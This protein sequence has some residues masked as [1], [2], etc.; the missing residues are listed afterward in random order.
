MEEREMLTAE[1][2]QQQSVP[3]ETPAVAATEEIAA[4]NEEITQAPDRT[5]TVPSVSSLEEEVTEAAAEEPAGEPKAPKSKKKLLIVVGAAAAVALAAFLAV[6][7]LVLKPNGTYADAEAALLAGNF[8]ECERLLDQI[9]NHEKTPGLRSRMEKTI[10]DNTYA[11]A[12]KALQAGNFQ[13]C[14]RL[15][16][17]IPDHEKVPALRTRLDIAIAEDYIASGKLTMAEGVLAKITGNDRAKE[18]KADIQ[19]L[20]AA[21]LVEKGDVDEAK[22]LLDKIPEHEDPRQLH[23]KI[24]YQQALAALELG[25]YETAYAAFSE[26]GDYEDSAKQKDTVYYEALAFKSLFNVQQT[27]KNP[28][29]LRVTKVSFYDSG[30]ENGELDAV[31]EI[32]ATNSY[33][34]SLGAYAYDFRLYDGTDDSGMISHSAYADPDDY[35]ELLQQMLVDAILRKTIVE[36]TVDVARMNRLLEG[37]A[38]FKID[39]P[40]QSGAVVES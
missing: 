11:D 39:L 16:D 36:T 8:Q 38:S 5:E 25:D 17:K 24:K 1:E 3:E 15:M 29:S 37:N 23:E 18:L 19:Y 14:E 30:S 34:G 28:A 21:E 27:L 9:P 12:E 26:L 35:V 4:T 7:L 31:Y 32:T 20:K 6:Y 22:L 33:G 40:F 2:M 13:E 10:A